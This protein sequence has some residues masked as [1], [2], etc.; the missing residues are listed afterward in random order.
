MFE[1]EQQIQTW[2]ANIAVDLG[3]QPGLI[4]E[5]ESHL[6]D[7]VERRVKAGQFESDAWAEALR[8]LGDPK[9]LAGEFEK[10]AKPRWIAVWV[11]GIGLVLCVAAVA[12]IAISGVAAGKFGLVLAC[13]IVFLCTGYVALFAAGC[14][15]VWAVAIHAVVGWNDRQTTAF[16]MAGARLTL[17]SVITTCAAVVLGA[18]WSHDHL[19]Q[20]WGW[21]AR[22]IGGLSVL[23]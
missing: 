1:L 2:R 19:G 8:Q 18:W 3:N 16:R 21:G 23:A 17:L 13:H 10:L 22:E 20:W 4:D 15:A 12:W 7:D 9:V 6:R 14:L 11:V 5:L